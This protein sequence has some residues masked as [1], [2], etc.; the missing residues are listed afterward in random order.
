M[1]YA[2]QGLDIS[3]LTRYSLKDCS[4]RPHPDGEFVSFAALQ[5]AIERG[6]GEREAVAFLLGET[7]LSMRAKVAK[8]M[9]GVFRGRSEHEA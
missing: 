7:P 4:L 5:Q 2:S 3:R 1:S 9:R 6:E 8:W